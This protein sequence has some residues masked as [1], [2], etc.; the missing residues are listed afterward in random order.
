MSSVLALI[1]I[2]T[3]EQ[4]ISNSALIIALASIGIFTSLF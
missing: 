3:K 2:E 1:L 4:F